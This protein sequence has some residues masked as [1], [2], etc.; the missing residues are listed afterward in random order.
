MLQAVCEPENEIGNG[1]TETESDPAINPSLPD[2]CTQA[3]QEIDLLEELPVDVIDE[4]PTIS[5]DEEPIEE[6]SNYNA[7]DQKE[8]EFTNSREPEVEMEQ[9]VVN[10]D[11]FDIVFKPEDAHSTTDEEKECWKSNSTSICWNC[12]ESK[13]GGNKI[14]VLATISVQ[15]LEAN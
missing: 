11:K 10:N 3:D 2:E 12:V 4:E 5:I 9:K 15:L 7:K 8:G 13:R 6:V 14:V 1:N